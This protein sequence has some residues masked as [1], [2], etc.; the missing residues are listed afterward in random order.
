VLDP[1]ARLGA[2]QASK[3]AVWG[4]AETLRLE[5]AGEVAV[6]V[7]FPSGMISRHLET[8]TE[9]QPEHVRRTIGEAEDFE[10]MMASN[11]DMAVGPLPPEEA[12]ARGVEAILAG[13]RYVVTHGDLV[14]AVDARGAD[15]RTAAEA[16]R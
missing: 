14:R 7:V 4:L 1:A 6:T 15:L 5:L 2:Y 3:F 12:A 8:S 11:P 16:G 13:E 10:A 9:A